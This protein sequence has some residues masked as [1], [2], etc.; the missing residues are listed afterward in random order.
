[1]TDWFLSDV[2][3]AVVFPAEVISV[4]EDVAAD[5]GDT[6]TLFC[7]VMALGDGINVMWSTSANV[8]LPD[9]VTTSTGRNEYNG[10]LTL[11]NVT[12]EWIGLYTCRVESPFGNDSKS[13]SVNVTGL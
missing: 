10:T 9:S 6:V 12:L 3:L 4:S 11:T 13:I 1:M 7:T 5:Y 8:S 2:I